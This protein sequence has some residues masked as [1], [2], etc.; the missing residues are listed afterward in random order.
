M[1]GARRDP[2]RRIDPGGKFSVMRAPWQKPKLQPVGNLVLH[3]LGQAEL[4]KGPPITTGEPLLVSLDR[5][6]EDPENPRTEFPAPE[7]DELAADLAERGILQPIVVETDLDGSYL[8]RFGA[9]RFRAAL[10][11][12]L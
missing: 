12:G 7:L 3:D 11:A 1:P 5:L 4:F 6:Y 9:T 10:Q 8:I 2:S